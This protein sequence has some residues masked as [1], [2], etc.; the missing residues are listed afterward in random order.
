MPAIFRFS[1]DLFQKKITLPLYVKG[2]VFFVLNFLLIFEKT[3][4]QSSHF[5]YTGVRIRNRIKKYF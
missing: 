2:R 3:G 4:I 5:T 1:R